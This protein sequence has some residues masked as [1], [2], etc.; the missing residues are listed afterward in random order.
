MALRFALLLA[1]LASAPPAL[2]DH[3]PEAPMAEALSL[4]QFANDF[5]QCMEWSDG[6]STCQRTDKVH[7]S[8]PGILCQ[9]SVI[10]CSVP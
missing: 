2:A 7:C 8:T 1:A 10:S 6:C 5:P 3:R 4:Q 9:P